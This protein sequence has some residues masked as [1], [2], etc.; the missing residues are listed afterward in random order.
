MTV[1][2]L[3]SA[4]EVTTKKSFLQLLATLTQ[5]PC[6]E[7]QCNRLVISIHFH[8]MSSA[9]RSV[10]AITVFSNYQPKQLCCPLVFVSAVIFVSVL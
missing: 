9:H 1:V 3:Y 7:F 8:T 10:S 5:V 2:V 4:S 6:G